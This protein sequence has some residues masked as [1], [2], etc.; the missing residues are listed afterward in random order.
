MGTT[1]R[2]LFVHWFQPLVNDEMSSEVVVVGFSPAREP[3]HFYYFLFFLV[4]Y[5]LPKCCIFSSLLLLVVAA[6]ACTCRYTQ[7]QCQESLQYITHAAHD[8][9]T[10]VVASWTLHFSH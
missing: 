4:L 7:S 8:L 2:L 9:E 3:F 10:T 1:N 6:S 5:I